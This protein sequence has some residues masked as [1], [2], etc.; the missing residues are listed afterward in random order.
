MSL[1]LPTVISRHSREGQMRD[2]R[3]NISEDS[4]PHGTDNKAQTAAHQDRKSRSIFLKGKISE[5]RWPGA[6]SGLGGRRH[7]RVALASGVSALNFILSTI[8]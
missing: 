7:R 4:G 5:V 6:H 3:I 1:F 8:T 2:R